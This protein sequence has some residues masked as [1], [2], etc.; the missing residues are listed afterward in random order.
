MVQGVEHAQDLGL[1]LVSG[2]GWLDPGGLGRT[3]DR[4]RRGYWGGRRG[5][6]RDWFLGQGGGIWVQSTRRL[7][8]VRSS[9]WR[10]P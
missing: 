4:T 3:R 2:P 1:C 6:D 7:H 8:Q 10:S 5:R 9:H